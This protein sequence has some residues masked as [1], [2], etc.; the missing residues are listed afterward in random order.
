MWPL[1]PSGAFGGMQVQIV[2]AQ[3]QARTIC[4]VPGPRVRPKVPSKRK[5]RKGTR[6]MWKSRHCPY[7]VMLY[8]EPDDVLILRDQ[9]IIVT[10]IQ[11]DWLRRSVR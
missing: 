7:T 9:I 2:D 8:R 3:R 10:P 5:G 1:S 4:D 11:A 6:R